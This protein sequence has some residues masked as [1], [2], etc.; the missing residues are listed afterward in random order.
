MYVYALK[1]LQFEG[2]PGYGMFC[3]VNQSKSLAI[4]CNK[5]KDFLQNICIDEEPRGQ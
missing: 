2:I 3:I 1:F 5:E 4:F